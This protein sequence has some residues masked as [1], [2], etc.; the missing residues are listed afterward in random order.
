MPRHTVRFSA[1]G[2]DHVERELTLSTNKY[3][4]KQIEELGLEFKKQVKAGTYK[5]LKTLVE[6]VQIDP[7][8]KSERPIPPVLEEKKDSRNHFEFKE[9][10]ESCLELPDDKFGCS[11]LLIGATRSGK[12]TLM[13]WLYDTFFRTYVS[14]LHTGSHQSEIYKPYKNLP[15]APMFMGRLIKETAKINSKT[16][17]HYRFLH[18]IDDIIDKKNSK[19]LISLLT[20]GR[21]SRLTTII[22]GQELSIFNS[23]GRSNINFICCF[24]MGSD[25]AIEKVVRTYL[26]SAF[27]ATCSVNEMV[28]L[29]KKATENHGFF[30][31]DNI[32]D[33]IFLSRLSI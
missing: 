24:R 7:L 18:I 21:N 26:R 32:H 20:V 10:R 27:P 12:S 33:K 8:R 23:I 17:N 9:M 6:S 22:T 15:V 30:F 14:I 5:D 1:T 13:N 3:T 29:Y 19:E 16:S 31:I 4:E 11:F 25:M 2:S 28:A